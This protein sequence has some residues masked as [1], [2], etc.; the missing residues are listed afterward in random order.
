LSHADLGLEV[1]SRVRTPLEGDS[2]R[3]RLLDALYS[4]HDYQISRT[5]EFLDG[6]LRDNVSPRSPGF[7]N[8]DCRENEAPAAHSSH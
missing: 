3:A 1:L 2:A 4:S 8:D 6:D 7:K 5:N